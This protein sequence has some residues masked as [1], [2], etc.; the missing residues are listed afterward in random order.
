MR[1]LALFIIFAVLAIVAFV[2]EATAGSCP[3]RADSLDAFAG[4]MAPMRGAIGTTTVYSS[5]KYDR[6][7]AQLVS[8]M[9]RSNIVPQQTIPPSVTQTY[10]YSGSYS[11]AG[12]MNLYIAGHSSYRNNWYRFASF[13][14]P[15]SQYN[16]NMW[17]GAYY[18]H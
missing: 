10:P 8:A 14:S 2:S 3:I 7:H 12:Y 6:D 9:M 17:I 1:R 16:P 4:C 13:Y 5:G 11:P 18:N 15:Y